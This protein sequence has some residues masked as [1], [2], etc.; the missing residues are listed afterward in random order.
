MIRA[1]QDIHDKGII[2]RD[3]KPDNFCISA[4][5]TDMSNSDIYLIDFGLSKEVY[6]NG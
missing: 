4:G 5:Q 6:K 3:I 2:H 1:L